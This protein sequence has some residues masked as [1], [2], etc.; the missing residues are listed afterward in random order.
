[1][2]VLVTGGAGYIGA[3]V[4]A[5]LVPDE[6]VVVVDDLSDGDATR[7]PASVPLVRLD[8]ADPSAVEGLAAVLREHDVREIVH[9]AAKK[10]VAESVARPE[11]YAA[12]NVGGLA[13]VVAA[14]R[15]SSVERVVFSSSAAVYGDTTTPFVDEESPTLPVNP[16]GRTKLAGEWL[17]ADAAAALGLAAASLR[18][19]NVAGAASEPLADRHGTNLVPLVFGRISAGEAPQIF[20]DDYDTPDGTCVRDYIHVVDLAD[21][22]VAVLRS[23]RSRASGSHS[24]Y[25]VGTGSGASV[26]EMVALIAETTGLRHAPVVLP[27]RPGD[28]ARVVADPTR[29]RTEVGWTSKLSVGDMIESAWGAWTAR[30][31]GPGS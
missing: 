18:Y 17:T 21:A 14:A 15:D 22:H 26:A 10:Q 25:N 7:L 13:H 16:Y 2:T 24:V 28:P 4:V 3:H 5:A 20:G 23:L 29:L 27:R 6:R 30:A 12:Q 11:W 19:F 8:L 9:L 1:V 31:A